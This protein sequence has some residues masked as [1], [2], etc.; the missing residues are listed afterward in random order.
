ML[1][2]GPS[3]MYAGVEMCWPGGNRGGQLRGQDF[4]AI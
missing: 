4:L 2:V 3:V 1:L